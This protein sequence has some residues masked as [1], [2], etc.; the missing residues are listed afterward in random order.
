MKRTWVEV[1]RKGITGFNLMEDIVFR[2]ADCLMALASN[3][4]VQGF[5]IFIV[6]LC[7]RKGIFYPFV[8]VLAI[9]SQIVIG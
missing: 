4:G 3:I 6:T 2:R 8:F 9:L 5:L 1:V 7:F